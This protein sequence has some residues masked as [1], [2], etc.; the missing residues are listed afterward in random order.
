MPSQRFNQMAAEVSRLRKTFVPRGPAG[1]I[2]MPSPRH[3]L[4]AMAFRLLAHAEIEGYIEERALQIAQDALTAW[5]TS[6]RPSSVTFHMTAFSGVTLNP[7]PASLT[8]P[9]NRQIDWPALL[10]PTKRVVKIFSSYIQDIRNNNH[11]ISERNLLKILL[12]LGF[13]VSDFD[14]LLITEIND[15]SLKRGSVAHRS[16]RG[17]VQSG[18]NPLDEFSQVKRIVT[19]LKQVDRCFDRISSQL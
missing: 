9:S 8:A 3:T 18:I 16:V 10:D 13:K 5:R 2:A 14:P 7:P 12:P 17:H 19:G 1:S 11:G 6:G 4:R 15:F